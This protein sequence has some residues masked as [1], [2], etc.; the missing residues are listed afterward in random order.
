MKMTTN[1]KTTYQFVTLPSEKYLIDIVFILPKGQGGDKWRYLRSFT[2]TSMMC[3]A[4][5][6]RNEERLSEEE[7]QLLKNDLGLALRS[8]EDVEVNI[9]WQHKTKAELRLLT[10]EE[11]KA[12]CKSEVGHSQTRRRINLLHRLS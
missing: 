8:V 10:N 5:L 1:P 9:S 12:I 3:H 4:V 6:P 7:V 11:L 2:I